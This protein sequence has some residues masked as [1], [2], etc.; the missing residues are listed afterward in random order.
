MFFLPCNEPKQDV[1]TKNSQPFYDS[2]SHVIT[3]ER[4]AVPSLNWCQQLN[5]THHSTS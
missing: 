4:T 3:N 5:F 1:Y 2:I